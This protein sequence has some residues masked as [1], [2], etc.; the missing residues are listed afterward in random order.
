MTLPLDTLACTN[1]LETEREF[2][3]DHAWC[4]D[5]F[6]TFEAASARLRGE[7]GRLSGAPTDWRR[8]EITT[9]IFLLACGLFDAVQEHLRGSS[10]RL[11]RNIA[12]M[13]IGR[14]A[15]F[16]TE[17]L[18]G[19]QRC[20]RAHRLRG[21]ND[22]WGDA[23]VL[24][25]GALTNCGEAGTD[26]ATCAGA[27]LLRLLE[28]PLPASLRAS[29]L[30]VPS[31]FRRQDLSHHDVIA[32]A[33]NLAVA[34]EDR[35]APVILVGLRT[36][37]SYFLP[38]VRAVLE[39]AGFAKIAMLT[40][41]PDKGPS[42]A[43]F[44][45]LRRAA[46]S[47]CT[48]VIVDD[49]PHTAGTLLIAVRHCRQAGFASGRVKVL[50]P[51]HPARRDWAASFPPGSV[52]T[53]APSAWHKVMRMRPAIVEL[54]LAEY[55]VGSGV[56]RVRV[57]DSPRAEQFSAAADCASRDMRVARLKKVFE[58][59]IERRDGRQETRFFLVK[60]VGWGWLGYHAFLCGCRLA[61]HVPP[62]LGLRSGMLYV[63]WL[64]QG[65]AADDRRQRE[66]RLLAA[67]KYVASRVHHLRLTRDPRE[68]G[69]PQRHDDGM[70]RL[71][72]AL[73]KAYGPLPVSALVRPRLHR[74]IA[75]SRCP[76]PTLIDGRMSRCK[77]LDGP[78]GLVKTDY[79]HHGMGKGELNLT[80][81][82]YDLAETILDLE[83]SRAE[84]AQLVDLYV[85]ISGDNGVRSRLLMHKLI[86]GLSLL[87]TTRKRL[88]SKPHDRQAQWR[89]HCD[90]MRAWS[91]LTV[92][93]ARYCGAHC[94][95]AKRGPG[96][97][98]IV[99]LDVDGVIDRRLL[100]FPCTTAAGIEAISLLATHGA[101]VVINTARSTTEVR[102]YCT[103]YGFAGGAAEHGAF[104]WDAGKGVGKVLADETELHQLAALRARLRELP[105]VFLDERHQFSIRAF[106]YRDSRP[107]L[108]TSLLCNCESELSAPLPSLL[109]QALFAELRLDRLDF[110]STSIDT[111]VVA[112]S[113]DK[114][115]G[116]TALV[117]LLGVSHSETIAVGDSEPDL[118]AFRIAARSYAPSHI[119]CAREARFLGC[120]I[121]SRPYMR[122]LL[123]SVRHFLHP[124]GGIC[125]S[126]IAARDRVLGLQ[127]WLLEPLRS[128][129]RSRGVNLLRAFAD[130]GSVING[131]LR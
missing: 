25:A 125:P 112:R 33:R 77:W 3:E 7:I 66:K 94:P 51:T 103:A 62:M 67:G 110:H 116:L 70:K 113:A 131:L 122:G 129:D 107:G 11:P 118:A 71:E 74:I 52:V 56:A 9:N 117:N 59:L 10:L 18:I 73:G 34:L 119:G 48:A 106:L 54:H 8:E 22:T 100:G 15:R 23:L 81:A 108:I 40:I 121:A 115:T 97:G 17:V 75:S 123:E 91:F 124:H 53:L 76:A 88:F 93:A 114:G 47:G 4:L 12:A 16:S 38:L 41:Q 96:R 19:P 79:E 98:P 78:D 102:E 26:A 109:M 39:Q 72:D 31:P 27:Q 85:A 2:Y 64:P 86:A 130:P 21:W 5:P 83:L 92:Q 111:A 14:F 87:Q 69:L 50:A 61:R 45:G 99:A 104:V 127:P 13:R 95:P 60:S 6:P 68:G 58:A 105:G 128:A 46:A 29:I 120:R 90:M 42:P 55:L 82:A 84:E 37:G 30:A 32:L 126:C 20:L 57:V 89:M 24:F 43:D 65:E 1:V 28:R 44:R 49:P 36:S 35:S 101:Q 80:D 63:E